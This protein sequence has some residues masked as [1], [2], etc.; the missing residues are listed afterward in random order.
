MKRK[1]R[2]QRVS[3]WNIGITIVVAIVF[4]LVCVRGEQEFRKLRSTTEDYIACENAANQLQEASDYLTDQARLYTITGEKQYLEQYF[5]E[6]TD[7]KRRETALETL[8]SYFS[9]TSTFASLQSAM[10]NSEELMETEVY[11][12]KLVT[13]AVDPKSTAWPEKILQTELSAEDEMLSS[14]EKMTK[15]QQLLS[16]ESYQT[17]QSQ[18]SEKVKECTSSLIDKTRTRQARSTTIFSDMYL[19]MEIGVALLVA[20]MLLMCIVVRK[21]VV[22][23]LMSYNQSILKGEIFP[24]VGAAEL[25]NLAVTYNRVYEEN[26][27]TQRLIRHQA[28][29]DAM[30]DLLNRG[31]FEKLLKIHE[32]G[33]RPF[34]LIL[35]DVDT[36]KTVN[37]TYGHAVGDKILKKVSGLLMAAFRSIDFVCRIGGDEFAV[38]MV[39]MTNDLKYTI[40]GKIQAVNEQL[41]DVLEDGLPKV[42]LS[43]GVAFSE[44]E[45]PGE[46]LFKDA[47][48]ALYYVKEHGRNGCGFYE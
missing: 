5:T 11:A 6:V 14:S 41:A 3:A 39:E 44:R 46:S 27:E 31:S 21:L 34:A 36:F 13:E 2:I 43:V 24:V 15:A 33:D 26:Q 18:I 9:N 22:K 29:H 48:K 30:T 38:I 12:M 1:I 16:E 20:L 45:N 8:E 10:D 28:E 35:I 32:E 40:E 19:K 42:S 23:P 4:I 7:T 25:Q 37:D 17:A 47:D